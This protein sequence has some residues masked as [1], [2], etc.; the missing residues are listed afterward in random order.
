M[1]AGAAGDTEEQMKQVLKITKDYKVG[2][3]K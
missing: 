2:A 3:E 1:Y